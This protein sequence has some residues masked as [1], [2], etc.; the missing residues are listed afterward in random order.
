MTNRLEINWKLDG[1][2]D[3]QRYYCSETPID[4]ENLPTPTAVL[5]DD[6]FTYTDST[7]REMGKKY[8]VMI[9]SV[10]NSVEKVSDE[11]VVIFGKLWTPQNLTNPSKLWLSAEDVVVDSS[12]RIS[13]LTDLSGNN[14]HALQA[15][16]TNK[17]TATNDLIKFDGNDFYN[18]DSSSNNVFNSA[19][20]AWIF[21]VFKRDDVRIGEKPLIGWTI[22]TGT[23]FRVSLIVG[24]N[25]NQM[26]FG[27][28]RLDTDSY[29]SA[30]HPDQIEAGKYYIVLGYVDYTTNTI[31]IFVDGTRTNVRNNAF[32]SSGNTSS[33]SSRAAR[34][35]S[36]GV[37]APTTYFDGDLKTT[38]AGNTVMTT[39]ERQKLEGWAAH[40]YGLTDNLPIDHPYKTLVPVL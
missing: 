6:V 35:G 37:A 2:V 19:N 18:V 30:D 17:A 8:H 3:E 27:G 21:A 5:P 33:T 9:S 24:S 22:G 31:E 4:P 25:G 11:K 29:Q 20:K 36:N 7:Q 26:Y 1:F 14:Y 16:N 10:K 32:P 38:L 13:Q 34:V 40:K 15:T 39:D 12:N 23:G 28:R